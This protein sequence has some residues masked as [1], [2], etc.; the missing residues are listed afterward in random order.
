MTRDIYWTMSFTSM[1]LLSIKRDKKTR[2]L[3]PAFGF[4]GVGQVVR[5]C[6]SSKPAAFLV[7]LQ[8][9]WQLIL[10][11]LEVI[12]LFI[13]YWKMLR[14]CL[15]TTCFVMGDGRTWGFGLGN[16]LK[17]NAS[18]RIAHTIL[19]LC[20]D[21]YAHCTVST[22]GIPSTYTSAGCYYLVA[23]VASSSS[24]ISIAEQP[25]VTDFMITHILF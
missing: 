3:S 13:S 25:L 18:V 10:H 8:L 19:I 1:M 9:I 16:F 11:S 12:I 24:I 2:T 20:K 15:C 6:W 22:C 5:P 14:L 4:S 21:Q 17:S 23:L 7:A